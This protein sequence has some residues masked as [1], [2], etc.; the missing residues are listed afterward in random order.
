VFIPE[1][2]YIRGEYEDGVRLGREPDKVY[3]PFQIDQTDLLAATPISLRCPVAG[4]IKRVSTIAWKAVTTGGAVTMKVNNTAV[5][6]LSV[7]VADG[8][9]AGDQ[10]SDTPTAGHASTIV[11]VDDDLEI[12]PA[13][14]FDTAGALTGDIEI[15]TTSVGLLDGTLVVGDKNKGT[16]TT[17][18]VRGTYASTT[19]PDGST[20]YALLVSLPDP[21]NDGVPQYA[22]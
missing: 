6:G 16:A 4:V 8:G 22:G 3:V 15:E 2:S 11:A 13:A 10:D 17:G 14:A 12:L 18:D 5:D 1:A 21:G 20:A 9:G 19:D 7:T